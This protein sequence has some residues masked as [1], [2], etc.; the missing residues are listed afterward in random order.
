MTIAIRLDSR[1]WWLAARLAGIII[2]TLTGQQDNSRCCQSAST[3]SR[4]SSHGWKPLYCWNAHICPCGAA[5]NAR[6]IHGVLCRITYHHQLN[7]L[8]YLEPTYTI[9]CKHN[10]LQFKLTWTDSRNASFFCAS[11]ICD[12][13][14]SSTK[15]SSSEQMRQAKFVRIVILG[16][17]WRKYLLKFL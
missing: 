12:T 16:V 14:H 9:Q 7:G 5:V 3:F 2:W 11:N 4:I 15:Q 8:I 6:R 17:F 10:N 1:Q 13:T